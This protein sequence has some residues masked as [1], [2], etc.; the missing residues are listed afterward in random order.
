MSENAVTRMLDRLYEQW[1]HFCGDPAHKVF[2][3]IFEPNE[4]PIFRTFLDMEQ[5]DDAVT[6][7]I[8][9]EVT[10]AFEGY[11]FYGQ[12]IIDELVKAFA[13]TSGESENTEESE[14]GENTDE[15]DS[16]PLWVAPLRQN[17]EEDIPYFVRCCAHLCEHYAGLYDHI[18]FIIAPS[19]CASQKHYTRWL[20]QMLMQALPT[21]FKVLLFDGGNDV[22]NGDIC[23]KHLQVALQAQDFWYEQ[24]AQLNMHSALQQLA[25]QN[26]Q[27]KEGEYRKYFVNATI[28]AEQ[29]DLAG[30]QS[31]GNK[32]IA[33][34]QQEGWVQLQGM[35]HLTMG[36]VY[37]GFKEYTGALEQYIQAQQCVKGSE[38]AQHKK[39]HING[40][41]GEAGVHLA[42]KKYEPAAAAYEASAQ[43]AQALQEAI[44]QTENWYMASYCWNKAKAYDEAYECGQNS[45][46]SAQQISVEDRPQTSVHFAAEIMQKIS[47]K[48]NWHKVSAEQTEVAIQ[49]VLGVNWKQDLEAKKSL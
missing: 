20:Q 5:G 26:A 8:F 29:Q 6:E 25:E 16:L 12:S 44:L 22:D 28:A 1:D 35:M 13:A 47:S 42:Q 7:D 19:R 27:D 36:A 49:Q 33:L 48:W 23:Y 30:A 38:E 31:N 40:L 37:L 39:L 45:L 24:A 43:A 2:R 18:V 34:A 41:M 46:Q 9:L 4:L 15:G 32:A 11:D 10:T 3:W 17:K 14:Q 21:G